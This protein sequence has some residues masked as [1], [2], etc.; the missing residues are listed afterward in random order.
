MKAFIKGRDLRSWSLSELQHVVWA[1]QLG[2]NTHIQR[3][4]SARKLMSYISSFR[5]VGFRELR[6]F[7]CRSVTT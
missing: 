1:T 4:V 6:V 5:M 7:L 2:Q 3:F